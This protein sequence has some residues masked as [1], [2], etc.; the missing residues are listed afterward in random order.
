MKN[1]MIYNKIDDKPRWSNDILF[2]SFKAQIDNSLTRGWK[3]EDIIIGTNFD[4]EYKGIKN[5]LLTD[6]CKTNPF[7]NKFYGM[8]EMMQNK[9]LDDDFWFHDQ[10]AWQLHDDLDFPDFSGEIGGCIYVFTPEWNTCS[11]FVK[12]SAVNILEYIVDFMKMNPEYLESVQSDE[13]VISTLR[14]NR[15][16][17]SEYLSTIN[18]Q[19]NVGRTKMEYRYEQADKPVYVG[20]FVP[21]IPDSVQVFNGEDNEM[22]VNLIDK[23]LDKAF[24][25]HFKEYKDNF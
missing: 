18:T 22:K 21:S 13:H 5:Y 12:K 24:R 20:G 9:V 14:H 17:I 4:F 3:Q 25:K 16:E 8:L 23:K 11:L 6:I 10:D 7:C 2:N 1:V 15:T 19:Y